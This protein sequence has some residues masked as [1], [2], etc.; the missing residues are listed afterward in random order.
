[1]ASIAISSFTDP[2]IRMMNGD[3]LEIDFV[4]K[5]TRDWA[6]TYVLVCRAGRP[7]LA[8]K[9]YESEVHATDGIP[10]PRKFIFALY[11]GAKAGGFV[12]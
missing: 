6:R 3:W 7:S 9:M 8:Y 2:Q 4:D 5:A 11:H 12:K 1:M 10:L